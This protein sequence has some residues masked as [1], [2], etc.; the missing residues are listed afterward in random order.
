MP[1]AYH[2]ARSVL[3]ALRGVVAVAAPKRAFGR[4]VLRLLLADGARRR[5]GDTAWQ[6]DDAFVRLQLGFDAAE[7]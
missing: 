2:V 6:D 1:E 5:G 4:Q 3:V 7:H